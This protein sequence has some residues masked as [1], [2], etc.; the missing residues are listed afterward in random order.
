MPPQHRGYREPPQK[1]AKLEKSSRPEFKVSSLEEIRR[2]LQSSSEDG[3]VEVLTG[4]RNQLTVKDSEGA[5]SPQDDRLLL[6]KAWLEAAPGAPE[7]FEIWDHATSRQMSLLALIVS[8]LASVLKLVNSHYTYHSLGQPITKTLLNS[9][10]MHRLNSYLGGSHSELILVT[11]KLFNI[12]SS[13]AGGRER[14]PLLDS[15]AWEAKSLFKL[16]NMRRKSNTLVNPDALS[17]PDIRTLYILFIISFVDPSSPSSLKAA[18]LESHRDTFTSIFKGLSQDSYPVVR[19]VLEIA[20][21]GILSDPKMKR[22]VK[23]GLFNEHTVSHVIKLYERDVQEGPDPDHIPADVAHHFLLAICT[24]PGTGICFQDRGWYARETEDDDKTLQDEVD[25]KGRGI[26][27]GSKIYNKILSNLLKVLKAN[28]DLRQQELALKVIAACPELVAPYWPMAALTLE[29]RLSSKWIANIAFFGSVV[30]LPVP[31]STFFLPNSTLYQPSPPPLSSILENILPSVNIKSHLT[32]GLQSNSGLVRHC[33]ALALSK[34][35]IKYAEVLGV[36]GQVETALQEDG[37]DGQWGRR[38]AEVEREVRRRVPDFQVVVAFSQFKEPP[39][40]TAS[41]GPPATPNQARAALLSESAHRLLALYHQC[42]PSLVAEARFDVGKL[43]SA[44]SDASAIEGILGIREFVGLDNLRRLHILRLLKESD[45]FLWSS[46]TGT[47]LSPF[48]VLLKSYASTEFSA[49]R[50]TTKQLLHHLLSQSILFQ[51][52]ADEVYIWLDSLPKIRRAQDAETPDGAP[53]TDEVDGV[54]TF[55]DDCVQRCLKTPYRYL[56][57]MDNLVPAVE[58]QLGMEVDGETRSNSGRHWDSSHPSPLLMTVVEQIGAKLGANLLS[59]SDALATATFCR[60]LI[61]GLAG[62]QQDLMFLESLRGKLDSM[63]SIEKLFPQYPSVNKAMRREVG[64]LECCLQRLQGR[65]EGE[66]TTSENM[67]SA[68]QDFLTQVELLPISS[69]AAERRISAYELV[70]WFRLVDY[71]LPSSQIARCISII[72]RRDH[73]VLGEFLEYVSPRQH[74]LWK[75]LQQVRSSAGIVIRPRFEWLF[76]HCNATDLEDPNCLATLVE[77]C[78]CETLRETKQVLQTLFHRTGSSHQDDM[79]V[80]LLS[81]VSSVFRMASRRLSPADLLDLKQYLLDSP[82]IRGLWFAEGL[83]RPVESGLDLV[84]SSSFDPSSEL[85]KKMTGEFTRHRCR[86]LVDALGSRVEI[87]TVDSWL[88]LTDTADIIQ[89]L[90]VLIEQMGRSSTAALIPLSESVLTTLNQSLPAVGIIDAIRSRLPGLCSLR[91]SLPESPILE[92]TIAAGVETSFPVGLDGHCL[93]TTPS[94]VIQLSQICTT[95]SRSWCHRFDQLPDEISIVSFIRHQ[96]WTPSSTEIITSILYRRPSARAALFNLIQSQELKP[97]STYHLAGVLH[98]FFDSGFLDQSDALYSEGHHWERWYPVLVASVMGSQTTSAE[99]TSCTD[100][101]LSMYSHLPSKRVDLISALRDGVKLLSNRLPVLDALVLVRQLHGLASDQMQAALT[102]FVDHGLQWAVRLFSSDE[103]EDAENREVVVELGRLIRITPNIKHHYSEPVFTAAIQHRLLWDVVPPFLT[104]LARVCQHK[105]AIVNRCI[106]SIVQHAHFFRLSSTSDSTSRD[107]VVLL[108]H[109]LF[110]LHPANTCQPSHIDPLIH[111]YGGTLSISDRRLLSIFRSFESQRKMSTASILSRWS[112]S[113]DVTPANAL[114]ALK[115]LDSVRVFK[116]CL[117][118]PGWRS[119][120]DEASDLF[121]GESYGQVYDP[122]FVALLVGVVVVDCPPSTGLDWVQFFRINIVSLLIRML[123][124]KDTGLRTLALSQIAGI[125]TNIQIADVQEKP[126][127]IHILSLLKNALK[128]PVYGDIPRLPTV[129][130]VLL[131]HALRGVF[132]PTNFIYPH[133]ARFLLQRPEIDL[134]DVPMLYGMLYSS[135]DDWKKERAWIIK[136]CADGM[137]S[138][139]DW[140]VFKRRH[141]WDLLASLFQ[142]SPRDRS[143]RIGVLE[144]LANITCHR[145]AATS[146]VLKSALISWIEMQLLQGVREGECVPW[147]KIL[148]NIIAV[149]DHAKVES[150]T[151][152]EWRSALCRCLI[153]LLDLQSYALSSLSIATV[154]ILRLSLLPGPQ[155]P[156][157]AVLL[158]RSLRWLEHVEETVELP[159][160]LAVPTVLLGKNR[161]TPPLHPAHTLHDMPE[162][163]PFLVWG[164]SVEVLW[165]V[166]MTIEEKTGAWDEITRRLLIWRATVGKDGSPLGEWARREVLRN[167]QM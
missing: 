108:L 116:S 158:A 91:S 21:T 22:T 135:S 60:K 114:E 69:L 56:E 134:N 9:N 7:L 1:R 92:K 49:I 124:S 152:G 51:H 41:P 132:Y 12:V 85:D 71:P 62:K 167:L 6:V 38:R 80:T 162:R 67:S 136:F 89:L 15:F 155:T 148:D 126:H 31:S 112:P 54:V 125:E 95:S 23:I 46:K 73:D 145:Q 157:L 76:V 142:S 43:M 64:I 47:S 153:A 104:E 99:R 147:L 68:V 42:L 96:T 121:S 10:C 111:I 159:P 61:F 122:L 141:T 90:D 133:T 8:T 149:V 100:C 78:D 50:G 164:E 86:R 45:Q 11:L 143:I 34:C 118:F 59:A 151:N 137:K 57:E 98:A 88:P 39:P 70:D 29:P 120:E 115:S 44:F 35:L 93:S 36:F 106:Q 83:S 72:A 79:V 163:E 107:G 32:K 101:L 40:K 94:S 28:E 65:A 103:K 5:I 18:F 74:C 4:F 53:L 33:T 75:L 30:S 144:V 131:A 123:S 37:V 140:R 161:P 24:R 166:T 17:R 154:I 109:T 165:R 13:F 52:D 58:D 66:E 20:W 127:I 105:P 139:E 110:N 48:A 113:P 81:L 19:K 14:K 2:G 138:S 77:A 160:R 117:S 87:P 156:R 84:I 55:L 130:T 3:L 82:A 16:L 97:P 119:L 129:M 27:R 146:L 150:A 102:D 26:G 25:E 63:L 128:A